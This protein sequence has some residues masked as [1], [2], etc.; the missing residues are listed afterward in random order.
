MS[1]NSFRSRRAASGAAYLGRW[2]LREKLMAI[3]IFAILFSIFLLPLAHAQEGTLERSDW[4]K[5]F[6]EFQAK[7]TIVVADERQADRAM[8]VFDPVR[9]K[10]RFSPASTFKIPHTL[11]FAL[12]AGTV[13]DEFRFFDGTALTGGFAG[14]NQDQDLRST[15]WNSTVWVYELF[16]KEIGD[17][18][19]RRYLK[20]ST[21][22]NADPF[23]KWRLL[24]RRQPCNLGAEQLHPSSI[25]TSCPFGQ[26]ISAWS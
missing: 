4:R 17:D 6:S 1:N 8:L 22:V 25:V 12:D 13:R 3:R 5:F 15:M 26:N 20:K 14:H 16:A 21:M 19:A 2:A 10:K 24:D 18:K 9:S 11:F 7:G 23:D